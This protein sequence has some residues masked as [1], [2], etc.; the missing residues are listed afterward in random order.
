M[1]TWGGLLEEEA[2]ALLV[3]DELGR[4]EVAFRKIADLYEGG[5]ALLQAKVDDIGELREFTRQDGTR[6]RVVN[7]TVSDPSGRCR[8]VL[9]DEEVELVTSGKVKVGYV[10]K[11]IDGYV[12]RT[13]Y[14]L[15]VSS[16][17]WGVILPEEP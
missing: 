16:G 3:V 5:E 7:L 8:L 11:V 12:R 4:N 9:W 1:E 14:G 2:A 13:R 15:Q 17:K 6:G 10:V